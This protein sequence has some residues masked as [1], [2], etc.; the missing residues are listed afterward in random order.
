MISTSTVAEIGSVLGDPARANMMIGM[1]DGR[2]W[3]ARELADLAGVSPQTA[4]SHLSRLVNAQMIRVE[5]Q[6]RHRYHRIA[7]PEIARLIEQMHVT[8]AAIAASRRSDPG[9]ADAVMR[10]LRSC[11]DHLAGRIAVE[12]AGK[13]LTSDEGGGLNLDASA[14]LSRV[15][16]DLQALSL[17]RRPLCRT[18]LDWSER[19]PHVAGALGAAMLDRFGEMGWVRHRKMSRALI[20]TAAGERGLAEIFGVSA[21]R[22]SS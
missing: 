17:G 11:Y 12:L 22:S 20:L 4:S 5:K 16:I 21:V 8:G 6:G 2:A 19:R 18:C 10:E 3:T 9:P 14:R 7:S 13:L 1:L 15:G